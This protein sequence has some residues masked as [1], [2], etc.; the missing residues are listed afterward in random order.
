MLTPGRLG[1]RELNCTHSVTPVRSTA[2]ADIRSVKGDGL[3]I[4]TQFLYTVLLR[5][6]SQL[7][8][9]HTAH[10]GLRHTPRPPALVC[11]LHHLHPCAS[12]TLGH[13]QLNPSH[14]Q[15]GCRVLSARPACVFLSLKESLRSHSPVVHLP[16]TLP[17]ALVAGV[18]CSENKPCSARAMTP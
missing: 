15:G 7:D 8:L 18:W 13:R 10:C 2:Q 1:Q 16:T 9:G 5:T 3:H 17:S 12:F 6:V 14:S 11:L 4:R